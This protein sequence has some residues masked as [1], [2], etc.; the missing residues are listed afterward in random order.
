MEAFLIII[1]IGLGIFYLVCMVKVFEKAGY[2]AIYGILMIIPLVNLVMLGT[3]AFETWPIQKKPS[4]TIQQHKTSNFSAPQKRH[5]HFP[6]VNL[7]A[8]CGRAIS[9]RSNVCGGCGGKFEDEY[10]DYKLDKCPY[11]D[12]RYVVDSVSKRAN[13]ENEKLE[14]G[15]EYLWRGQCLNCERSWHWKEPQKKPCKIE[16]AIESVEQVE[17]I[18]AASELSC[19]DEYC[20][21][22]GRKISSEMRFCPRCGKQVKE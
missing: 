17:H 4:N 6:G 14:L 19:A 8:E 2:P 11:C 16:L 12:S 18:T 21:S 7:C 10:L 15:Y 3:L 22:C 1:Y 9:G 5:T 20:F 13:S